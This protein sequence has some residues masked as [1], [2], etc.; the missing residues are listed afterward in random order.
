MTPVEKQFSALNAQIKGLRNQLEMTRRRM[1][2]LEA[3]EKLREAGKEARYPVEFRSQFGEDMLLFDA[4]EGRTDG[5]IIEVGA[6]DGYRFSVSYALECLGWDSLLI[7]A[8]PERAEAARSRRKHARVVHA[9]LGPVGSTGETQFT[10]VDDHWDGMLSYHTT[11]DRHKAAIERNRQQS[12]T[13]SVP[14]TTMNELLADHDGPIQVAVIDVE[15]GEIDLLRGF[16]LGR[17]KPEMM[18]IEDN[19][20]SDESE[21]AKYMKAFPYRMIG[22]LAVNRIYVRE[23][24]PELAARIRG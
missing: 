3:R 8:I 19:T 2:M 13:V 4:F 6:F 7:E 15:G 10:V 24:L 1:Y 21:V 5:F 11:S 12:R 23:D 17:F 18:L 22:W 16:D 14:Y 20:R 9:A